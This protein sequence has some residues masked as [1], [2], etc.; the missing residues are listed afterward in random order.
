MA[1]KKQPEIDV[2]TLQPDE[3]NA[4]K[5]VVR[6]FIKRLTNVE[7]ELTTLK[8]DR[9][10]LLEEF[11]EKLDIKTLQTAMKVVKVEAEI[12]H[13]SSYDTFKELL[14]DDFVNEITD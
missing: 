1:K 10:A 6:E 7:N 13:R 2:A 3:L 8:E 5:E 14:V 9:K 4:L 11:S 12:Q